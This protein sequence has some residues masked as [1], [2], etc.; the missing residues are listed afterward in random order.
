MS[1]FISLAT[2]LFIAVN[3]SNGASLPLSAA[4]ATTPEV[5]PGPGLPSLASLNLTSAELYAMPVP[6]GIS[7]TLNK[8]TDGFCGA[9]RSAASL[10]DAIACY[11]YLKNI[12][13]SDCG[14]PADN[15]QHNMCASGTA[16]VSGLD[17]ASTDTHLRW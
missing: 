8:R 4:E 9:G 2:L 3:P 12:S 6:E 16:A 1:K 15:Q 7:A 14:I 11:N 5:I 17:L 10:N 13:S